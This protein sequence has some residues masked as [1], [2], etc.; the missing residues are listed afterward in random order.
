M[1][2]NTKIAFVGSGSMAEAMIAGLVGQKLIEPGSVQASGPRAARGEALRQK[3][4]IATTTA[5]R[6]AVDGASV[7]VLSIKPQMLASVAEELRRHVAPG[8]LVL[9][10]LAG[11]ASKRSR[12]R[13]CT[14]PSRARCPTRRRR[15]GKA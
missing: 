12:R 4:G 11:R 15:S 13:C 1:L 3:Y 2:S 5:N 9:S 6:E 10:I 14:A 7:V 8:A